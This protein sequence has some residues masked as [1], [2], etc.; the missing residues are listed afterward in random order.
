MD[1]ETSA[2]PQTLRWLLPIVVV[3]MLVALYLPTL[4]YLVRLWYYTPVYSHGF[5]VIPVSVVLVWLIRARLAA[6]DAGIDRRGLWI[7]GL[8]LALY[9]L[10]HLIDLNPVKAGSIIVTTWGTVRYFFGRRVTRLVAF[11]M[12]FLCFMVVLPRSLIDKVGFP[13]QLYGS[14]YAAGFVDAMGITA[15]SEG[16]NISLAIPGGDFIVEERCSGM[17]SM[18]ALMALSALM[19]YLLPLSFG[20]KVILFVCAVPIALVAN[21]VRIILILLIATWVSVRVAQ[22]FF[23]DYSAPMIFLIALGVLYLVGKVLLWQAKRGQRKRNKAQ[24]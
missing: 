14:K 11:P 15:V 20:R 3:A 21:L 19:A 8:G 24:A 5:L 9:V 4:I 6:A 23:H 12:F 18:V 22:T 7:L 13:M 10:G 16:T 1:A 17:H 2:R